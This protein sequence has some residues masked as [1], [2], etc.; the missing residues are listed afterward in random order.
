MACNW[1]LDGPNY[2]D[3]VVFG[4]ILVS[5]FECV[6]PMDTVHIHM[7]YRSMCICAKFLH[8]VVWWLTGESQKKKVLKYQAL[9]SLFLSIALQGFQFNLISTMHRKEAETIALGIRD[10]IKIKQRKKW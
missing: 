8:C 7:P 5:M 10:E 9:I 3:G 2:V 6:C 4:N 1:L